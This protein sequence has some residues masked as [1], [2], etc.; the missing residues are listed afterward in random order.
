MATNNHI[1]DRTEAW[2]DIL[3]ISQHASVRDIHQAYETLRMSYLPINRDRSAQ[4]STA[5]AEQLQKLDRAF[6]LALDKKSQPTPITQAEQSD[7][8]ATQRLLN[9]R[10][11]GLQQVTEIDTQLNLQAGN[12]S[13]GSFFKLFRLLH[14]LQRLRTLAQIPVLF[15]GMALLMS[16][17]STPILF[18]GMLFVNAEAVIRSFHTFKYN[19]FIILGIL[20][21]FGA[22]ALVSTAKSHPP[23]QSKKSFAICSGIFLFVFYFMNLMTLVQSRNPYI[24]LDLINLNIFRLNLLL[25]FSV[26]LF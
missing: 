18:I 15:F 24:L 25:F 26:F 17:M 22:Y 7:T 23:A 6:R 20:L 12:T 19:F 3:M 9:N 10:T 5:T 13:K 16:L 21:S 8:E 1:H 2:W 4:M 14:L 11:S